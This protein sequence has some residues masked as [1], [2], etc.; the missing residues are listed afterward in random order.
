MFNSNGGSGQLK[1]EMMTNSFYWHCTYVKKYF[2]GLGHKI[3][4][5][6]GSH[7]WVSIVDQL[8][9]PVTLPS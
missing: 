5:T 4:R 8:C 1:G 2:Y 9:K 3:K 6:Y 7:Y